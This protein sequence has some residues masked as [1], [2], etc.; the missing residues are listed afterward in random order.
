[1][2]ARNMPRRRPN[3]IKGRLAFMHAITH[4]EL[5]AIDLA[6]DIIARFRNSDLPLAFYDD[7]VNIAND[8]AET[9]QY[10]NKLLKS[11]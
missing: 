3:S 7:W 10:V 6:W 11:Q 8:E 1:M 4:I 2:P 9:L 5:N